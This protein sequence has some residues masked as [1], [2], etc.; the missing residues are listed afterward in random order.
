M[1]FESWTNIAELDLYDLK[2]GLCLAIVYISNERDL[3]KFTIE[4]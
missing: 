4:K 3:I 1:V 2:N